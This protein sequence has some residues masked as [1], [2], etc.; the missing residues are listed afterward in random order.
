M[1]NRNYKKKVNKNYR[2]RRNYKKK[3][4][5][6]QNKNN[7]SRNKTNPRSNKSDRPKKYT[8]SRNSNNKNSRKY[9]NKRRGNTKNR[10][11][12]REPLRAGNIFNAYFDELMKYLSA[13]NKFFSNFREKIDRRSRRSSDEYERSLARL[14]DFQNKLKN[15]QKEELLTHTNSLPLDNQ[16]STENPQAELV[17]LEEDLS[18]INFFEYHET[19]AQ[20]ARESFLSDE[21]VSEGTIEDYQKYKDSIAHA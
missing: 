12:K 14:R 18:T 5:S 21:E 9:P 17:K 10:P 6:S 4:A 8:K 13:R 11:Q 3:T 16:F 7:E 20:K 19:D 2:K 1:E 15:W